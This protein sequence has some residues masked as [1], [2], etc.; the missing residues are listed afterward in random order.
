M[1]LEDRVL[2]SSGPANPS[3]NAPL[4]L[5]ASVMTSAMNNLLTLG[6]AT[7]PTGIAAGGVQVY[8]LE[9]GVDG[10]LVAQTLTNSSSLE[11]R[12][13][14]YDGNGNLVVQSDGQSAGRQG[15][16]I[17]QH[18]TAGAEYIEVQGL[19]GAGTY[20]LSTVLMPSSDPGQ[21]VQLAPEFQY[22][23][24]Q[25]IAVGDFT[26]NGILD[27][28]TPDGVHLGTGDGTFDAP[29]AARRS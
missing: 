15:P 7:I 22:G 5:P 3:A 9:P 8:A 1:W 16:S 18:V 19:S 27:I 29:A 23:I 28:V 11:L 2:L 14:L 21:T 10:R 26:N 25:P 20:S 4:V 13:S 12:L 6:S 17:D 24:F